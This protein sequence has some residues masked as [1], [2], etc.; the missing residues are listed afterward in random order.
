MLAFSEH[1]VFRVEGDCKWVR[2]GTDGD[3]NC[4]FHAYAY[5]VDASTFR[6]LNV[7]ERKHYVMKIKRFL[8]DRITLQ[9]TLQL[10]HP[11]S[12]EYFLT[13]IQ[14]IIQ[15]L[16][17]PDLTQQPILS[18]YSYI[19]LLYKLHPSLQNDKKFYDQMMPLLKQYHTSIQ[20]YINKDG[21]WMYDS[22]LPLFMK[23]MNIN[24]VMI[25]HQTGK[26][27]THYPSRSCEHMI[28]MYHIHDHYESIGIYKEEIMTR[29]FENNLP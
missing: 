10:I 13:V 23:I 1:K 9:D 8:A 28:Y 19:E 17:I 29:V 3:G 7:E 6:G 12:F 15:P 5:S 26:P 27:I 24:I 21:T 22:L 20:S 2:T 4:F 25:S 11:D 16:A 14:S 18:L